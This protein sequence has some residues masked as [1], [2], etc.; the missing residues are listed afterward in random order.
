[1]ACAPN[2]WQAIIWTNADPVHWRLYAALGG[3]ELK[4]PH[5][6]SLTARYDVSIVSVLENGDHVITTPHYISRPSLHT[7]FFQ[8]RSGNWHQHH[9]WLTLQSGWKTTFTH[10]LT[11]INTGHD[12]GTC[13][14]RKKMVYSLQVEGDELT[15]WL[16]S[17]IVVALVG[18]FVVVFIILYSLIVRKV[19]KVIYS[20]TS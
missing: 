15:S 5:I 11:Q 8:H 2:R 20:T 17:F 3:D 19:Q 18:F 10:T 14:A 9:G 7:M 13:R 6:S 16:V 4:T 1:M 12:V